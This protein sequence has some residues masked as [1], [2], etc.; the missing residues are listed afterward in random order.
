[1]DSGSEN[2][3]LKRGHQGKDRNLWILRWPHIRDT[4]ASSL[5]EIWKKNLLVLQPEISHWINTQIEQVGCVSETSKWVDFENVFDFQ[6][7]LRFDGDIF[8]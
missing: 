2:V 5:T 8:D 7:W 4:A 1:M 3:R 6:N